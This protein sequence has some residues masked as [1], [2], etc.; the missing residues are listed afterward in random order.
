MTEAEELEPAWDRPAVDLGWLVE[1]VPVGGASGALGPG[2]GLLGPPS[3]VLADVPLG[4]IHAEDIAVVVA[5]PA[6]FTPLGPGSAWFGSGRSLAV[7]APRGAG[8]VVAAIGRYAALS[9]WVLARLDGAAPLADALRSK[10][11]GPAE[12]VDLALRLELP[13]A[14]V[15]RLDAAG[16]LPELGWMACRPFSPVVR[17]APELRPSVE[18]RRGAAAGASLAA[19][20]GEELAVFAAEDPVALHLL[21]PYPRDIGHALVAWALENPDRLATVGLADA[22][23]ARVRS[24]DPDLVALVA[25][26][27]LAA[28]PGL[29]E[30]RRANER[31]AGLDLDDQGRISVSLL[32]LEALAAPD[33]AIETGQ[34]LFAVAAGPSRPAL[35]GFVAALFERSRVRAL[36]LVSS[37]EGSLPAPLAPGALV[38]AADGYALPGAERLLAVAREHGASVER[39]ASLELTGS[40]AW[41]ARSVGKARRA[42]VRG[43]V[44]PQLDLFVVV[45]GASKRPHVNERCSVL[46]AARAVLSAMARPGEKANSPGSIQVN[47][48]TNRP[49]DRR[50]R[51]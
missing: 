18:F 19:R 48:G 24:P 2:K 50:F 16:A 17:V 31:S 32:R 6:G 37:V 5:P 4:L 26:D 9:A 36:G 46:A 21:S 23:A 40:S 29:L 13:A 41:V 44:S 7:A 27:L 42:M 11:V 12:R 20:A 39:G 1:R 43:A 34:G 15:A 45:H 30:E 47:P 51:A 28:E 8:P 49:F 22:M 25:E 14:E 35:E 33:A 3:A 38:T 10:A